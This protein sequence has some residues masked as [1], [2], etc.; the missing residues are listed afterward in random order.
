MTLDEYKQVF[1][2]DDAVGW[3][4][5]DEALGKLY[6]DQEPR[7]YAPPLHYRL[8]GDDPLDGTSIYDSNAQEPHLHIVSYGMSEL[9][10][11]E[12]SVGNDF[13][14]WGFEFTFRLRPFA[15][16]KADPTWVIQMMNNIARYVN[17]SGKW[18]EEYHFVPAKGPIRLD[19]ETDIVGLAFVLDPEL[20]KIT[21]PH[22]EVAFLQ[23]VGLT[24][25][26]LEMLYKNPTTDAVKELL[27]SLQADNPLLITDLLRRS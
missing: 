11:N 10:Y 20:G 3:L 2:E 5:L 23:M 24:A 7:H 17:K 4:S 14:K 1:E 9:Y 18:F 19:T 26:E 25:G 16:D 15:A 27:T 6:P 8:G 13:S 21:T 12:E 22:G